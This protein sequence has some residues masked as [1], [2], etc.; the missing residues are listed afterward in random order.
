MSSQSKIVFTSFLALSLFTVASYNRFIS[1]R[2]KTLVPI[3]E[4]RGIKTEVH[5]ELPAPEESESLG[6]TV[7]ET[8]RIYNYKSAKTSDEVQQYYK[9]ILF[10]EKWQINNE[11]TADI[12][13]FTEYKREK[14]RIK[15]TSSS[16]EGLQGTIVSIEIWKID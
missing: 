10:N 11:G 5:I 3:E 7:T 9:N 14:D 8:N 2:P 13:K 12:F 6:S 1:Y 16:Q 4:V 15:I